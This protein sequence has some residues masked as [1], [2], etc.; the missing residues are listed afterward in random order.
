MPQLDVATFP[1]QL[2]WL[3]TCFLFLYLILSSFLMPKVATLL[4][5]RDVMREEKLNLASTY[6]EEAEALLLSYENALAQARKEA[7]L[8]YQLIVNEVAQKMAEKKR[9]MVQKLQER[10]HVA[11]Q[12]LYRARIEAG[13]DIHT[14]AQDIAGD[15]LKK[16]T[17]YSYSTEQLIEKKDH[18]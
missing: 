1:S 6:R 5:K 14:V 8:N 18:E 11:E 16:L 15:I 4:E 9:E 7:H 3:G 13:T 10:L 17:G 12:D 2:F